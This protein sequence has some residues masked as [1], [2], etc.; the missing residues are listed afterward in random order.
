MFM[1]EC[2]YFDFHYRPD[3]TLLTGTLTMFGEWLCNDI[4]LLCIAD[5]NTED[6]GD[7]DERGVFSH[8]SILLRTF[9]EIDKHNSEFPD[10]PWLPPEHLWV[11]YSPTLYTIYESHTN[12]SV[13]VA[14]KSAPSSPYIAYMIPVI[15]YSAHIVALRRS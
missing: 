1:F 14:T 10:D 12:V 9:Q 5:Q 8:T 15:G 2:C 6:R 7:V 4:L 3:R 11:D 13:Q